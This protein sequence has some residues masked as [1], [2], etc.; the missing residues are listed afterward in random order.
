MSNSP[1]DI[2]RGKTTSFYHNGKQICSAVKLTGGKHGFS[3]DLPVAALADSGTLYGVPNII[4]AFVLIEA[5]RLIFEKVIHDKV[6]RTLYFS[7]P[8]GAKH[9]K[10][11][12][13]LLSK[14]RSLFGLMPAIL[15]HG[16]TLIMEGLPEGCN[17][18]DRPSAWYFTTLE[19]FGVEIVTSK[20]DTRLIWKNRKPADITFDYP[21]MTATVIAI[22]AA[23]VVDDTSSIKNASVEPS[24]LEELDCVKSMG[25]KVEGFLPDVRIKGV[26][27]ISGAEWHVLHDRVHACT[28]ITAALLTRGTITIV[29]DKNINIP[30]FVESIREMGV[31]VVD[32][33]KSITAQFPEQGYLNPVRIDTGSEPLFSSDWM[34][35]MVLLLATRAKGVSIITDNVFPDRLQCLDNLKKIGLDN[36]SVARTT[37]DGRRALT[38]RIEGKPNITL[39]GGN[40]GECSDLRGATT[41]LL[42]ALV[43]DNEVTIQDDFHLRRGYEDLA[44]TLEEICK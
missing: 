21:S 29:A 14:S 18:G 11:N 38:A 34:A 35:P 23:S 36:V 32:T 17:M 12:N 8:Y 10:L 4:D 44:L 41:L 9:I 7:S 19:K 31:H 22:A 20:K 43:A 37:I 24:C 1:R 16:H 2:R 30:R 6:K 5:L 33:G 25:V 40:I 39:R 15:S 42:S 3:H 26:S 28:Y 13:E 27:K